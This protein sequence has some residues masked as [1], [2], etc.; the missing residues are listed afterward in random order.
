MLT[1]LDLVLIIC[2]A[3]VIILSVTAILL[4]QSRGSR[5][6]EDLISSFRE[7][8]DSLVASYE[9]QKDQLQDALSLMGNDKAAL[10]SRLVAMEEYQRKMKEDT[11]AAEKKTEDGEID[12]KMFMK[13]A[14]FFTLSQVE[15]RATA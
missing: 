2:L 1:T 7:E 11:E 13:T 3:L 10:E 15:K 4:I 6:R 5:R 12:P 14:A 8:R 9:H